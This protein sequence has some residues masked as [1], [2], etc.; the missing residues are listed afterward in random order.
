MLVRVSSEETPMDTRICPRCGRPAEHFEQGD[1]R[2]AAGVPVLASGNAPGDSALSAVDLD[3]VMNWVVG[4]LL[5]AA[6]AAVV[7]IQARP[8]M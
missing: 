6:T 1:V 2:W 5:L 8:P 3:R 4:V 7:V